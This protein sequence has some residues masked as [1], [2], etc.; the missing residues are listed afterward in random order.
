MIALN[1]AFRDS[2]WWSKGELIYLEVDSIESVEQM[3][4][5]TPGGS[6]SNAYVQITMKTGTAHKIYGDIHDVKRSLAL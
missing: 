3:T 1:K 4:D 5:R 2:Y 6:T